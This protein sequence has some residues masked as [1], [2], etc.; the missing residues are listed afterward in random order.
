MHAECAPLVDVANRS[1]KSTHPGYVYLWGNA[2]GTHRLDFFDPHFDLLYGKIDLHLT[3][4][5]M[6]L[7]ATDRAK[8]DHLEDLTA[9]KNALFEDILNLGVKSK[10]PV[11]STQYFDPLG[12]TR[13][14]VLTASDTGRFRLST[15]SALDVTKLKL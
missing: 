2:Y 15:S 11:A 10:F 7:H 5:T 12:C 6:P 14:D 3:N 1:V 13:K 4:Q 8:L 9:L